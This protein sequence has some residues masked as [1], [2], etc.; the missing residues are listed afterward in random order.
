MIAYDYV[1]EV[2]VTYVEVEDNWIYFNENN[3]VVK[4][5]GYWEVVK[6]L[7]ERTQFIV[8]VTYQKVEATIALIPDAAAYEEIDAYFRHTQTVSELNETG[9]T[10][11]SRKY[12]YPYR[13]TEITRPFT[14]ELNDH[15]EMKMHDVIPSHQVDHENEVIDIESSNSKLIGSRVSQICWVIVTS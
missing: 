8:L 5:N 4:L 10:F 13:N 6:K 11:M 15:E 7:I 2:Y 3:E 9:N 1:L 12:N 14:G